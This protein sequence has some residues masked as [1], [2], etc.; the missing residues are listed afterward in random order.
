[1]LSRPKRVLPTLHYFCCLEICQSSIFSNP[2]CLL[3]NF[4]TQ[5]YQWIIQEHFFQTVNLKCPVI[6]FLSLLLKFTYLANPL[7]GCDKV[8]YYYI[9]QDFCLVNLLNLL[10]S[11]CAYA[12]FIFHSF[13]CH[14]S[15]SGAES[16]VELYNFVQQT[17]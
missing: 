6:S 1:M 8:S 5:Y 4:N 17:M 3:H 12:Y 14:E 7:V 13:I 15:H 9:L 16:F 11:L 2:K 10:N